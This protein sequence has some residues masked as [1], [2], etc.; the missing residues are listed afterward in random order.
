MAGG[1]GAA[2]PLVVRSTRSGRSGGDEGGGLALDPST[3]SAVR[4]LGRTPLSIVSVLGALPSAE[5]LERVF[6]AAFPAEPHGLYLWVER[7]SLREGS[8]TVV[9]QA[10]DLTCLAQGGVY[11]CF[12]VAGALASTLLWFAGPPS[13]Q[14]IEELAMLIAPGTRERVSSGRDAAAPASAASLV[15]VWVGSDES[16]ETASSELLEEALNSAPL[17]A[18]LRSLL[19][20]RSCMVLPQLPGATWNGAHDPAARALRQLLL[21]PAN[22][23]KRLGSANMDGCLLYTSP[24]PRD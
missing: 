3:A 8:G 13:D 12:S 22:A 23:P 24:S 19:P 5:I 1:G 18:L 14:T 7:A 6:G 16:Q 21:S 4:T 15:W 11:E 10:P 9:L 17:G 2:L 20:V